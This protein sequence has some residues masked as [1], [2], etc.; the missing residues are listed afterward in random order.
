MAIISVPRV[1]RVRQK[2]F[3]YYRE[4][5]TRL[6]GKMWGSGMTRSGFRQKI[7]ESFTLRPVYFSIFSGGVHK[8]ASVLDQAQHRP[9]FRRLGEGDNLTPNLVNKHFVP[10]D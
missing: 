9:K 7:R 2:R 3:F 8:K 1:A 10:S 6:E 4:K 5:S